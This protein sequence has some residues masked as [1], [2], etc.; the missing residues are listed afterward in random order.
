[1]FL[2]ALLVAD[3]CIEHLC[4]NGATCVPLQ[5][6]YTCTCSPG[7]TGTYCEFPHG[8]NLRRV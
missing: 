5:A 2:N 3:F 6:S 1:M 4:Q 8:E 7:W